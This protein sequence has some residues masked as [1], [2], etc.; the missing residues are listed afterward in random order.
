MCWNH[1]HPHICL[2]RLERCVRCQ[3]KKKEIDITISAQDPLTHYLFSSFLVFPTTQSASIIHW[4]KCRRRQFGSKWTTNS[5][6]LLSHGRPK[7]SS[8]RVFHHI[9]WSSWADCVVIELDLL[10]WFLRN[11]QVICFI[12]FYLETTVDKTLST[13][14]PLPLHLFRSLCVYVDLE[15][16]WFCKQLFPRSRLNCEAHHINRLETGF[17]SK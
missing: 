1:F 15:T 13:Q 3:R 11:F 5:T 12:S 4:W 2:L 8:F 17:A 7:P 16:G 9:T 10:L 14:G 6:Y